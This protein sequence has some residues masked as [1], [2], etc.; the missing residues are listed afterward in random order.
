LEIATQAEADAGT[1]DQ[2]ALTPLK[3][4][5]NAALV[6]STRTLTTNPPLTGGGDLSTNRTLDMTLA[7]ETADGS[8]ELAT[9]IETD[10]GTDDA[11]A[12]SPLKLKTNLTTPPPIGATTPNTI[13]MTTGTIT[14]DLAHQGSNIGFHNVAPVARS[15]G[16]SVTFTSDKILDAGSTTLNEVANVLCTLIDYLKS[17]GDL[18]A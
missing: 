8:I 2:R 3:A 9:Q 7:T 1:D 16:W 17:R 18:G 4:K 15:T 12:V 6:P 14:G 13:K 10:A 5:N 11:R